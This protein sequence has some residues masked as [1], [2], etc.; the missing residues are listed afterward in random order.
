MPLSNLTRKMVK[1]DWIERY[2]QAF[3]EFQK[4]VTSAPTLALPSGI[5][6]L[7]VCSDILHNGLGCASMQNGQVIAYVSQ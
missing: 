2:E 1:Y 3:Q 6:G 7:V 4:R 5:E